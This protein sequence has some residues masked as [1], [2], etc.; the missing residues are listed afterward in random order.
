MAISKQTRPGEKVYAPNLVNDEPRIVEYIFGGW[1]DTP[2]PV[3]NFDCGIIPTVDANG[4]P[5]TGKGQNP[6]R[7]IDVWPDYAAA[8]VALDSGEF[9]AN[10][11]RGPLNQYKITY[12]NEAQNGGTVTTYIYSHMRPDQFFDIAVN[13]TVEHMA[14]DL[15]GEHFYCPDCNNWHPTYRGVWQSHSRDDLRCLDCDHDARNDYDDNPNGQPGDVAYAEFVEQRPGCCGSG[16]SPIVWAPA[17]R[18]Q[19]IRRLAEWVDAGG[20]LSPEQRATLRRA[21]ERVAQ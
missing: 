14:G 9:V 15:D 13:G 18:D 7:S 16:R 17:A 19:Q 12:S 4:N 2:T 5:Y 10:D 1:Y 8:V 21:L 11:D 3:K 6:A 20:T